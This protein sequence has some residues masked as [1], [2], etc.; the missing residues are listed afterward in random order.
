M[1]KFIFCI[2]VCFLSSNNYCIAAEDLILSD[3]IREARET[4]MAQ[5]A[6]KSEQEKILTSVKDEKQTDNKE[7]TNKKTQKE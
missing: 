5:I 3:V 7:I 1:N 4:Q 2:I 6:S